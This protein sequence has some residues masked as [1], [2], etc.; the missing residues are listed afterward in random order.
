MT[1]SA[2]WIEEKI[3]VAQRRKLSGKPSGNARVPPGQKV[4]KNFPVLDLGVRPGVVAASW[5]LRLHGLVEEEV[6]L[7]WNA[8]RALPQVKEVSD[9]H[10]VTHWT[11]FDMDWEGVRARDVIALARP[12]HDAHFVTL[13]SYDDYTTNLPLEALLDDD[14]LVAHSV[15]GQPITPEHGGPV[16]LVVP[17]RYGWKSAKWLKSIEFHAEDRPGFW[18]ERGYHDNADPWTEER[19][20]DPTI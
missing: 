10:C 14:V 4:V 11:Q 1:N 5:T 16:R 3:R 20:A 13:A 7:D 9:F 8:L 2:K 19:Y 17:S 6:S 18:E 15:F 12:L